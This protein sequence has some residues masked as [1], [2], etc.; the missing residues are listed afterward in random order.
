MYEVAK[1]LSKMGHEVHLVARRLDISQPKTESLDGMVIHRY[2][3]GI[4]FSPHRAGFSDAKS[5]GSYRGGTPLFAW[6]S[7]ELY[8]QTLFPL[9][10]ATEVA[11]LVKE[12]SIDVIFERETSF[13]A[14]AIASIMTGRP[15][16][17]EVIG[18]RV[19]SLQLARSRKIVAYSSRMFEGTANVEKVELVT[20]AVDSE[21]FK[22]D[23]NAG[24]EIRSLYSVGD[25]PVIGFVGTFQEWQG[26]D[27]L[28]A[29]AVQVLRRYPGAKFLMVGPYYS[30]TQ[31][32][33][34]SMGIARSF[35]FTGPVNYR[36]VP[37]YMNAADVLVAPYNPDAIRSTEQVRRYGLGS[38]LK[39]F[40]YMSVGKPSITTDIRPISDAIRDG[41][42]GYLVP[43]GAP[44]QLSAAIQKVLDNPVEAERVG[45]MAREE[46]VASYSWSSVAAR[47]SKILLEATTVSAQR[48]N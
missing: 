36:E 25:G 1:N 21:L 47:I 19:T 27:D 33:V 3:R 14:G 40:E 26:M 43:P 13:G 34:S 48:E 22:P 11:R 17:L 2:Q 10:I 7:Y 20:G 18:N 8:L 9:F 42:T 30:E 46:V 45:R 29:A 24:R 6:K 23:A 41:V 16:V 38:P 37:S 44:D 15:Y 39:V 32:K 5:Q 12:N 35:I 31:T 28:I 4:L